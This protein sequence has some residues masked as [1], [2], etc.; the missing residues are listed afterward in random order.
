MKDTDRSITEG[1][2]L[3]EYALILV[4]VAIVVLLVLGVMGPQVGNI[5]SQVVQELNPPVASPEPPG[6]PPECYGSGL[7]A[8]MV[9]AMG[10]MLA[11]SHSSLGERSLVFAQAGMQR[12]GLVGARNKDLN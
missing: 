7:L 6:P 1:Q 2:G 11:L 8:V 12:F 9:A 3:L 4:L 10:G 5:F